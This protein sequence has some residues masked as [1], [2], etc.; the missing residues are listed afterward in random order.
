M[1]DD[2]QYRPSQLPVL[3]GINHKQVLANADIFRSPDKVLIQITLTGADSQLLAN[4]LEQAEP[5]GLD[6]GPK[7]VQNIPEKREIT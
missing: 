2:T 3:I 5:I 7:P 1:N 4:F 6:F